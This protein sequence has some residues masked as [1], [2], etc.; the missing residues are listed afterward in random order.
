MVAMVT[1]VLYTT[2]TPPAHRAPSTKRAHGHVRSYWHS[3]L[4]VR[5]CVVVVVVVV[6]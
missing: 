6:R 4:Y 5:L 3:S 2:H 1:M